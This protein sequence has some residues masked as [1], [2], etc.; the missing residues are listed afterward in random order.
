M[1]IITPDIVQSGRTRRD[2]TPHLRES[3]GTLLYAERVLRE[4]FP[5][6]NSAGTIA[7]YETTFFKTYKILRFLGPG[8]TD[9]DPAAILGKWAIRAKR[10]RFS[11]ATQIANYDTAPSAA[12]LRAEL[13]IL[14]QYFGYTAITWNS[15]PTYSGL[16]AI[17]DH[18]GVIDWDDGVDPAGW[19]ASQAWT[20]EV[21]VPR[22]AADDSP[23]PIYG[24]A[25]KIE[26]IA[27]GMDE[28]QIE[29]ALLSIEDDERVENGVSAGM[30][31]TGEYLPL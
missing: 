9:S 26:K 1:R 23:V 29:F 22:L 19:L 24:A 16:R 2:Y 21:D 5:N 25:A 27:G 8:L 3:A 30:N 17:S 20:W 4:E 10:L 18:S 13:W 15:P 31:Y 14:D 6:L 7:R 28:G 11:V 12:T